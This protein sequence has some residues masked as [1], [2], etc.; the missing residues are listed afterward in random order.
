MFSPKFILQ[1][2]KETIQDQDLLNKNEQF[3]GRECNRKF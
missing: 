1:L 3:L 2:G